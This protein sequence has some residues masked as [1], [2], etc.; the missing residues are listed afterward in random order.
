MKIFPLKAKPKKKPTWCW[1]IK[2]APDFV[3]K[4]PEYY[5]NLTVTKIEELH[6][7]LVN[8]LGVATGIR[9]GMVGIVG[10]NY[11]SLDNSYQIKE[12]LKNLIEVINK[13]N[14]PIEK[15]LIAV[16]MIAYIQPF[17]DGNKWTSR[18]LGNALLLANNYCPLSYRSANEIEYKIKLP[19]HFLVKWSCISRCN[20]VVHVL[21][22][23]IF[24]ARQQ[25]IGRAFLID[26]Y[27][28]KLHLYD[29][30]S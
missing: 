11:K 9:N 6:K 22:K 29:N 8:E 17:E 28:L 27:I 21:Q 3:L 15:A 19:I 23:S 26:N 18:I 12:A 2:K 30:L 16:L 25:R 14:N 4:S 13:T 5:K 24:H 20:R 10:T 7:L 1:T